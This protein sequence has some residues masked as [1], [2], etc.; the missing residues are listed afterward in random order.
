MSATTETVDCSEGSP[1]AAMALYHPTILIVD[2]ET[3]IRMGIAE[4]LKLIGY[5]VELAADGEEALERFDAMQP[6]PDLVILDVMM[7][8]VDGFD[9]LREIRRVSSVPVIMLTAKGEV[10][11][12]V[13][14]FRLGVDDYLT[15]PFSLDELQVRIQ[16]ILRRTR[17]AAQPV[18]SHTYDETEELENGPFRLS[19]EGRCAFWYDTPIRL[20]ELEF[21]FLWELCLA[22]GRVLTHEELLTAV[23]GDHPSNSLN[24]LRVTLNRIR[25]KLAPLNV[26][27]TLITNLSKVGY[28]MPDFT[29]YPYAYGALP[30]EEGEEGGDGA[31]APEDSAPEREK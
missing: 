16:A 24:V 10:Q 30:D 28:S 27:P 17:Q 29:K 23:W 15:K 13:S 19:M 6:K 5:A 14:A 11:S 3:P 18:R 1:F 20:T 7:P 12:K 21:R 9:V 25:R 4:N 26:E 31:A 22:R 8:K 2:D